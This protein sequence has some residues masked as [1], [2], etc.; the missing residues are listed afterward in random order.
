[1][2]VSLVVGT[3]G[4]GKSYY[5]VRAIAHA[6]QK[7]RVVATNV[8]LV[9]DWAERLARQNPL[10]RLSKR[11]VA[12]RAEQYRSRVLVSDDLAELFRIRLHGS[13]EG[14]GLMVLDE[15]HNW[16]NARSWQAGGRDEVVRFFTQHRKLGWD[17]L[18]ITQDEQNIDRQVR[19]LFEYLVR[20]R[21]LRNFKVM[22]V[23]LVP[24]SFF[25]A[26]WS[27]SANQKMIVKREAFRLHRPTA[28]LYD[29]MAVSHGL[30]EA[31]ADAVWLPRSTVEVG[32]DV[33]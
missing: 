23:R 13:G 22:G 2:S 10:R 25:I 7:G 29:S 19:S 5:S 9:D 17:V 20:L 1:M 12:R 16:M 28:R 6:V 4:S 24:V 18:L 31:P 27:W 3:P 14:R 33:G 21:N 32:A 26:I 11:A 15:A 30:D 8:E